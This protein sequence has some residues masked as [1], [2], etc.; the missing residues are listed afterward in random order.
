[1]NSVKQIPQM[2]TKYCQHCTF[3]IASIITAIQILDEYMMQRNK[4]NHN[5]RVVYLIEQRLSKQ[6]HKTAYTTIMAN[7]L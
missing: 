4:T 7:P 1:M 6:K 2:I 5:F 3:N